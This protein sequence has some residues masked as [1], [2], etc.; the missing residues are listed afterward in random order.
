MTY[1]IFAKGPFSAGE[2]MASTVRSFAVFG[3]VFSSNHIWK[4]SLPARAGKGPVEFFKPFPLS[5]VNI[6]GRAG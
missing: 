6:K 2:H 1:A 5:P 4:K 3:A